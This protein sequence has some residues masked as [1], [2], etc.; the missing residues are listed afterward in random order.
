V[1]DY[2]EQADAHSILL[3]KDLLDY[4]NMPYACNNL[5]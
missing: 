4:I 3:D 1:Y 5:L 2:S